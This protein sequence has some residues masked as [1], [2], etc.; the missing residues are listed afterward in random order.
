[1]LFLP[2]F[3]KIG[4]M[5]PPTEPLSKTVTIVNELG[6]HA[7]SA[8]KLAGI[9]QKARRR[10]WIEKNGDRIDATSILDILTLAAMQGTSLRIVIEDPVDSQTL[11]DIAHLVENGFGE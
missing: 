8:A 11:H 7:R 3:R 10:V 5:A 6:L 1:M 4:S 2:V 9:A